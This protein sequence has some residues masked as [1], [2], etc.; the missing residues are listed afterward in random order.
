[1]EHRSHA[2]KRKRRCQIRRSVSPLS[3]TRS[4][5]QLPVTPPL[6]AP[7][8]PWPAMVN[9][10]GCRGGQHDLSACRCR[11][12]R[13]S[14]PRHYSAWISSDPVQRVPELS[15]RTPITLVCC[16]GTTLTFPP[17]LLSR[18]SS[19][20][21]PSLA[22]RTSPFILPPGVPFVPNFLCLSPSSA[23]LV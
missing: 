21:F 12:N 5:C 13:C 7:L 23:R 17:H 2:A 3:P 18:V 9:E 22:A 8:P 11:L 20:C 1:M 14:P 15:I 4:P 6:P 10:Q 19:I 16:P